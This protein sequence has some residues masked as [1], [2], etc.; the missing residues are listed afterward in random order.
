MIDFEKKANEIINKKILIVNGQK[1]RFHEI[2]FYYYSKKHLD[3]SCHKNEMQMSND[4]WYFHRMG[5]K[6]EDGYKGGT[7]KGLDMTIGSEKNKNYG[8][9]LIR[10]IQDCDTEEIIEG[11]CKCVN[12]IL[13]ICKKTSIKELVDTI[14]L[15]IYDNDM[16]YIE[17][18]KKLKKK[19][20]K[21]GTRVGLTLA[22]KDMD[23]WI[24]QPYRYLTKYVKK[25]MW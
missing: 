9:I 3:V 25:E 8:G 11:P 10:T 21:T 20:I 22:K 7:Y 5:K 6:K 23:K 24:F 19:K 14:S 12:K 16:L 15:N 1:F 4:Q 13:E 17:E 18:D 2:E